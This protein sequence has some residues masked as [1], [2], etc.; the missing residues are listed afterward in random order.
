MTAAAPPLRRLPL[1][2]SEPPYDDE[3]PAPRPQRPADA[4]QG[5]LALAFTMPS[6]VPARPRPPLH[7]VSPLH[8]VALLDEDDDDFGPQATPRAA[9]PDPRPWAARLVQ[10]LVDAVAGDRPV[11]Q[12]VRWTSAEVYADVTSR[13]RAERRRASAARALVRTVHVSEPDDGVAEVAA[14][15]R[16]GA[17]ATAV[18]LRLEGLDG[19]WQC[20][21]LELG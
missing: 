16:R 15:V 8:P 17:R 19:R 12:L 14:L 21:A 18:A 1:P 7:L 6:G 11:R 13:A 9:L 20:T 10:A 4:T 2:V 3:L 5:T